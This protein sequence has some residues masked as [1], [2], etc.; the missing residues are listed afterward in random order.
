MISR[1][2]NWVSGWLNECKIKCAENSMTGKSS[3]RQKHVYYEQFPTSNWFHI[4]KIS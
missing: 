1:T 3:V 4:I 2:L